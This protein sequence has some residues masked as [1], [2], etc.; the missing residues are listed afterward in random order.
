MR[1]EGGGGGDSAFL[2]TLKKK[3]ALRNNVCNSNTKL[4][5]LNVVLFFPP[6]RM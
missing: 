1:G 2:F 3:K 4:W 5:L 6:H